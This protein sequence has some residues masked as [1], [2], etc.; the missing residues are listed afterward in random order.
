MA[1]RFNTAQTTPVLVL[2]FL[3]LQNSDLPSNSE[4]QPRAI[5][6]DYIVLGVSW[7]ILTPQQALETFL[8]S[9]VFDLYGFLCKVFLTHVTKHIVNG[10]CAFISWIPRFK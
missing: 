3:Y 10:D 7:I 8:I 5:A 2:N 9:G 6:I 1:F 4:R